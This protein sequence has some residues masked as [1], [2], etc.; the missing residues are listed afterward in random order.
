MLRCA[1]NGDGDGAPYSGYS[2]RPNVMPVSYFR[3]RTRR[4]ASGACDRSETEFGS[5][6]LP[7][8]G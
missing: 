4:I 5:F 8:S 2:D 6:D 1:R 7:H 3:D